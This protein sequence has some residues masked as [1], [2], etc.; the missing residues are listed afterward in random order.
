[1]RGGRRPPASIRSPVRGRAEIAR[2][3]AGSGGPLALRALAYGVQGTVAY[4]VGG[5]AGQVGSADDG[6][7]TLTLR[8]DPDG[9][10]LIMSDMDNGNAPRH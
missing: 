4:I 3:Y 8:K 2:H 9:R 10:W 7:F 1:M 5:Y 6:K